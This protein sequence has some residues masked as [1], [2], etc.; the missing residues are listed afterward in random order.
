MAI[1][2]SESKI[3]FAHA[4]IYHIFVLFFFSF[5]CYCCCCCSFS[6]RLTN[7]YNRSKYEIKTV[8][9]VDIKSRH[10][11]CRV[12]SKNNFALIVWFLFDFVPIFTSIPVHFF[13]HMLFIPSNFVFFFAILFDQIRFQS[14]VHS[15]SL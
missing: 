13:K 5:I 9:P 6:K 8:F 7:R 4:M 3:D 12:Y 11:D 2:T 1:V 15:H 10:L 14:I